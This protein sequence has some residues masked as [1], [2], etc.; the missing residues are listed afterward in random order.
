MKVCLIN[1]LYHPFARGGAERVVENIVNGLKEK[2]H[3]VFVIT[4]KPAFKKIKNKNTKVYYFFPLNLFWI[5]NIGKHNFLCRLVWHFFDMFSLHSYFKIKKIL[6]KEKPDLVITHNLKGIGYLIPKAIDK[7]GIKYFHTLHDVQLAIPSGILIKGKEN[8]WQNRFFLTKLYEKINKKLFS[9]PQVVISPSDWLLDFYS[10]KDFFQKQKKIV[11]RNPTCKFQVPN[12]KLQTN[13]KFQIS[14]SVFT[15]LYVGQIE[16]HK[17]IIFLINVFNKLSKQIKNIDYKLAIIGSGVEFEKAKQIS[18]N[19]PRIIF[20]GKRHH[21]ELNKFFVQVN[22]LVV[23][24][25]CYEN[26]PTVIYEGLSFG[27]PV[28][29]SD[30]GGTA[31]LVKEGE[32]GYIFKA[33]NE[34]DLLQK[35]RFCLENKERIKSMKESSKA[36]ISDCNIQN[37]ISKIMNL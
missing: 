13:S 22:C 35:M 29:A 10:K 17:G 21:N 15:F 27:I 30:V 31:E 34:D 2:G 37:Y 5:G 6:Q 20:L 11:L 32:N 14:N 16:K 4:S 25:L 7:L 28:L 26:S 12:F 1:N 9:Y 33:G 23:P 24:S 19:N 8:N 3:D 36:S 18:K